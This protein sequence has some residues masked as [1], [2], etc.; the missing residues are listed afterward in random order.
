MLLYFLSVFVLFL[1]LLHD[2][3]EEL[4]LLRCVETDEIHAPVPAEVPAVEPIPVLELVPGLP[5]GEEVIVAAPLHVRDAW[6]RSNNGCSVRLSR[7]L[8]FFS[9]TYA[10][11]ILP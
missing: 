4:E 6:R 5:P 1:T 8:F 11:C 2:G 10:S 3:G 9:A 7:S